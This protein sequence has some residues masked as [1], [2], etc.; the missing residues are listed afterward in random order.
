MAGKHRELSRKNNMPLLCPVFC[1]PD[2]FGIDQQLVNEYSAYI[3]MAHLRLVPANEIKEIG[4]AVSRDFGAVASGT[5]LLALQSGS[6]IRDIEL[7]DPL[8]VF[9]S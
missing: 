7:D 2:A 5:S 3:S 4:E 1:I 8:Q 9:K 6:T